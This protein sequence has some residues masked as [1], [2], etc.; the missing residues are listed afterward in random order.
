MTL[1]K[2]L[3]IPLVIS[4]VLFVYFSD[5]VAHSFS[6]VT[7]RTDISTGLLLVLGGAL[8]LQLI[9]HSVRAYKMS[10]LLS[11]V[12]ESTPK[13]QFR[14]LSLG[15]L[16]NTLLPFRL[17]ELIRA[18]VIASGE[19]LSFGFALVLVAMERAIDAIVLAIMGGIL[20][21]LDVLPSV[22]I[23]YIL[24]LLGIGIVVLGAV[25]AVAIQNAYLV[26]TW[27]R[28]T[29]LF[30]TSLKNGLRFKVWSIIYGLQRSLNKRRL[31]V[32]IGLT[33]ASWL[34]YIM[35]VV[36]V[37]QYLLGGLPQL[38]KLTLALGPYFGVSIPAGP[39]SLGAFSEIANT[40]S[41]HISLPWD[42]RTAINLMSWALLVLPISSIGLLFMFTK[43]KESLWR[44]LP[45]SASRQSMSEKL[46]RTEDVSQELD[47]FLDNY[48]SGNSLSKIVHRM[49]LK[50]HF[51]LMKYF[52]GGSDAITILALQNHEMVVKKVIPV[53]LRDRLQAQYNWLKRRS[54]NKGMVNAIREEVGD[55]YY[56]IDLEY[57]E[58]SV[59]FFDVMHSGELKD[60]QRIFEEIWKNLHKSLYTKTEKVTDYQAL[61]AYI[62]KHIVGCA[63]KASAV[64]DELVAATKPARIMI[65]G[66]Q[67][68]NLYQILDKITK[69]KRVMKDLATYSRS[70]EVHGDFAVDNILVSSK[71]NKPLL[72]DPAP[73]GNIINGPVFDF[74]KNMQSLYC[75]YEFIFRGGEPVALGDDGKSINYHDRRSTRY[76]Q[77]CDYVRNELAPKYLDEGEQKA[78]LFHAGALHIRRLK[79]QVYQSP[80]NVLAIYA[81]GV[82][83]LNDFLDQYEK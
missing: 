56:A 73:D 38:Q 70:E 78:V 83:T 5:D 3:V 40:V 32:Y 63:E 67:Y 46:M 12:K 13:F 44:T 36:L 55:G 68:H 59:M 24:L 53:E 25:F 8:I 15:Y 54:S 17:G 43:T 66:K 2:F 21:L 10:Y 31:M 49:E 47:A 71:T 27:H 42:E 74:G 69:N 30:N 81:V 75:G 61:Q 4:L 39:A 76:M 6:A 9:G 45:K 37:I 35:S 19:K 77:L 51:R 82:K 79:H 28:V 33:V 16:F 58:N 23:P 26:T 64:S 65:N 62:D 18:Q 41:S 52:K 80:A 20:V 11:P 48:F 14:A 34:L 57:D 72:I 50:E 7:N 22:F 29:S 60:S 1:K